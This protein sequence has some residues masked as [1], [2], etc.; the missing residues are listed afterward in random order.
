MRDIAESVGITERATQRIV[1]DLVDGGY[2][3]R[4]RQGR[5]NAYAVRG[6][7]AIGLPNERDVDLQSLLRVLLPARASETR[8]GQMAER[9]QSA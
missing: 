7:L 8:R 1:A 5:R 3:E 4:T 2:I 6:D 9:S